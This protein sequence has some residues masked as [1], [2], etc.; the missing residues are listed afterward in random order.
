MRDRHIRRFAR[1]MRSSHTS[2]STEGVPDE[3]A[4]EAMACMVEQC[5]YVWFAHDDMRSA[6]VA[7]DEAVQTVTHA[8]HAAMFVDR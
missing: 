6:P 1:A 8:W 2:K 7:V 4:T 5:C 3:L